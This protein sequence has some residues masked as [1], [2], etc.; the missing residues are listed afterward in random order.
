L[1]ESS[2]WARWDAYIRYFLHLDPDQM[3]DDTY[4]KRRAELEMTLK[5][6]GMLK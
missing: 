2:E 3:D 5:D 6:V 1:V 4:I